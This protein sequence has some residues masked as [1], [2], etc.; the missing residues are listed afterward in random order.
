MPFSCKMSVYCR[1]I[2]KCLSV[3]CFV[4]GIIN[5]AKSL[6]TVLSCTNKKHSYFNLLCVWKFFLNAG[7]QIDTLEA[8]SS[9]LQ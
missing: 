7:I 5:Y 8:V 4:K 2:V 6:H 3:H 1:F 9:L